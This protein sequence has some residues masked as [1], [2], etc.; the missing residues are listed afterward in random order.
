MEDLGATAG[1]GCG[2]R[3][4]C[5]G[6]HGGGWRAVFYALHVECGRVRVRRV[7]LAPGRLVG[8]WHQVCSC[9]LRQTALLVGQHRVA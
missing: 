5:A 1:A 9:G 7:L 4:R 8:C 3:W 6:I 2:A